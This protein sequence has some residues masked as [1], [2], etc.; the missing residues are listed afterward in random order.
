M[1]DNA[2]RYWPAA[3]KRKNVAQYLDLGEDAFMRLLEEG[4]M[5]RPSARPIGPLLTSLNQRAL[6]RQSS[7]VSSIPIKGCRPLSSSYCWPAVLLQSGQPA[8]HK[9]LQVLVAL[10]LVFGQVRRGRVCALGA[11]EALVC[12]RRWT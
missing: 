10:Q 8:A 6:A 9:A 3:M 7:S 2:M 12:R 1:R 4:A 11:I 5:P